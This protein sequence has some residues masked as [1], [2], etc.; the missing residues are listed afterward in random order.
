MDMVLMVL[1]QATTA[2]QF[3]TGTWNLARQTCGPNHEAAQLTSDWKWEQLPFHNTAYHKVTG[4]SMVLVSGVPWSMADKSCLLKR[5]WQT[6]CLAAF[7]AFEVHALEWFSMALSLEMRG[8]PM[9]N[10][11]LAG[12]L[13]LLAQVGKRLW[14]PPPF[15]HP[16]QIRHRPLQ[17]LLLSVRRL[18][19]MG[20]VGANGTNIIMQAL[21]LRR[22]GSGLRLLTF[23]GF[24]NS[25]GCPISMSPFRGM[26]H[27]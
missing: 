17:L 9:V 16:A 23:A 6:V 4:L 22:S 24:G 12:S 8:R 15:A 2:V 27:R 18:A 13:H 1:A 21:L 14:C 3:F 20:P 19:K 25:V 26:W 7:R 5:L 10:T 11:L